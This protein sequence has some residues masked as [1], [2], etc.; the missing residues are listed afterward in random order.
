MD[1]AVHAS[2][3]VA[4]IGQAAQQSFSV[5]GGRNGTHIILLSVPAFFQFLYLGKNRILH[6]LQVW[7]PRGL[8]AAF[9][10]IA[11]I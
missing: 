10:Q 6:D 1:G 2:A 4:A 9:L 8:R 11:Q 5:F 3:A 7:Q